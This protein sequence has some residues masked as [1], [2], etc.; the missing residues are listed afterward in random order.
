[1]NIE[2]RVTNTYLEHLSAEDLHFVLAA[3]GPVPA[4][5][6]DPPRDELRRCW[7]PTRWSRGVLGDR[8]VFDAVFGRIGP[9]EPLIGIS[10]FLVFA[11]A[12]HGAASDLGSTTYVTEWLGPRLMGARLRRRSPPGVPG[13]TAAPAL[14]RRA[15]GVLH[16]RGKRIGHRAHPVAACAASA[17]RSSDRF[18]SPVSSTSSPTPRS[19]WGP[20][21]T[22]RSRA[23]LYRGLS[24]P[25]GVAGFWAHRGGST[26]P[27]WPQHRPSTL[28]TDRRGRMAGLGQWRCGGPPRA[29]RAALVRRRVRPHAP[30][31]SRRL[32]GHRRATRAVPPRSADPQPRH[33]AVPL[34]STRPVVRPRSGMNCPPRTGTVPFSPSSR[35]VCHGRLYVTGSVGLASLTGAQ[36]H[37]ALAARKSINPDQPRSLTRYGAILA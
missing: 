4:A 8:R 20:A 12:V 22:G 5:T 35:R 13:R 31:G 28:A 3:T 30:P 27:G 6:T 14:L 21:P 11:L 19:P 29:A 23:V 36:R 17:S 37:V 34:S 16:P 26:R 32:G 25:G 9:D 2:P 10:P 7:K 1:M 15:P 24:R 18:A 33:R